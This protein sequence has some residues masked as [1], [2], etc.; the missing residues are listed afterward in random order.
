MAV[1]LLRGCCTATS[2]DTVGYTS[3]TACVDV[4]LLRGCCTA[5]SQDT[6]GYTTLTACDIA[7]LGSDH[8]VVLP[9][10][11][12]ALP[13]LRAVVNSDNCF[14]VRDIITTI[15][16]CATSSPPPFCVFPLFRPSPSASSSSFS[17][18]HP[19]VPR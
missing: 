17:S 13:P 11:A 3:L 18:H 15:L 5:T 14:E 10:D 16:R 9:A 8:T 2:Q 4:V 1:V 19:G 12:V 7:V 6:V